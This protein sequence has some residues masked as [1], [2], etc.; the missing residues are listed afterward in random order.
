MFSQA[1]LIL[2][3]GGCGISQ[4]ALG[5]TPP[6][7]HCSR[8]YASYWNAFL[9]HIC[10][11]IYLQFPFLFGLHDQWRIQGAPSVRASPYRPKFFLICMQF[12]GKYGKFVCWRPLLRG[13][14]D[15]PL[16]MLVYVNLYVRRCILIILQDCI[17]ILVQFLS[18]GT[19]KMTLAILAF[20]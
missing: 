3:T 13:I 11:L 8:Q 1:S 5:Q 17:H 12:L 16:M 14:L 6:N 7:G 18:N 15:P 10:I 9:L 2:F 4:H 19:D 20:L